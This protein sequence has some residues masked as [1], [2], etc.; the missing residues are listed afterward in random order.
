MKSK[1]KAKQKRKVRRCNFCKESNQNTGLIQSMFRQD[2]EVFI[3]VNCV[4]YFKEMLDSET[5]ETV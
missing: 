4:L 5:G 3:C 1:T 2:K